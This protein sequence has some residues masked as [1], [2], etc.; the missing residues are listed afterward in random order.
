MPVKI[1][2][3]GYM[4]RIKGI[5]IFCLHDYL[6]ETFVRFRKECLAE[7]TPIQYARTDNRTFGK[8]TSRKNPAF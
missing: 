8:Y 3:I 6:A 2:T 4:S 1:I 5:S 7:K